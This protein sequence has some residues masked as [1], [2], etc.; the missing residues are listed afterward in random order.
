MSLQ[1]YG[2]G[3]KS[4][5]RTVPMSS[6]P[7]K[8]SAPTARSPLTESQFWGRKNRTSREYD[9]SVDPYSTYEEY[10]AAYRRGDVFHGITVPMGSRTQLGRAQ[11]IQPP[12]TGNKL[13]EPGPSIDDLL[14][15][16]V[17]MLGKPEKKPATAAQIPADEQQAWRWDGNKYVLT[18]DEDEEARQRALAVRELEKRQAT[19]GQRRRPGY[20]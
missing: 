18:T 7:A 15:E 14:Q 11:P 13:G 3:G 17:D 16:A 19:P 2:D 6:M 5:G 20:Y 10:M 9:Y 12:P 4:L 8:A 1:V